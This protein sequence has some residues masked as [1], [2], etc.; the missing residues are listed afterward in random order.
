[1]NWSL[2]NNLPLVKNMNKLSLIKSK[3]DD[4]RS[5]QSWKA[6]H[7]MR[8]RVLSRPIV[9][10][11]VRCNICVRCSVLILLIKTVRCSI[12]HCIL[13]PVIS[14]N[15]RLHDEMCVVET[16]ITGGGGGTRWRIWLTQCTTRRKVAG[17]I[18][19]PIALW[20]WDRLSLWQK[21]VSGV[22]PGG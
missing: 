7:V 15:V 10:L 1:M 20:P 8:T 22:Y 21:W 4:W 11:R 16:N 13:C 18:P 19:L 2:L 9:F 6:R 3:D 5:N 12:P 14:V 17:S